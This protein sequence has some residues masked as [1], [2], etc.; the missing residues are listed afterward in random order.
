MPLSYNGIVP[1]DAP[2]RAVHITQILDLLTG[3]M[4]DQHVTLQDGLTV[5]NGVV[6][7]LTGNV[8][9]VVTGSLVGNASTATILQTARTINGVSF[10]GS[11]NITVTATATNTLTFG[12]HLTGTSY[13]GSTPITIA[14]DATSLDTG[15]TIVARDSSGNFSAGVITATLNGSAPAGTLTGT[16]LASNVVSSSL[17]SVGTL[18][19]LT[20]TATIIG[21]VSGNAGTA[22]TLQTPRTINGVSFDGSANITV[23][24]AAGTLT[25]ATLAAN[26]LASSLTS[27]GT[28]SALTVTATITGSVSGNAGTATTLQTPRTIN[29]VSFDGSANITITATPSGSAGG[30]LTGTYPNPSIANSVVTSAMI[31]DDTIVDADISGSA[32]ITPSKISGGVGLQE[33]YDNTLGSSQASITISSIP[34]TYK[35]L[36][37]I[38]KARTDGAFGLDTIKTQLNGVSSNSYDQS[39]LQAV[40][41]TVTAVNQASQSYFFSGYTAGANAPSSCFASTTSDYTDYAGSGFKNAISTSAFTDGVSVDCAVGTFIG[42]FASGSAVSSITIFPGSSPNFVTGTRIT[43][44][45]YN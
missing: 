18:A 41:G 12:T 25:G 6:G 16:V 33:I 20:V 27:V 32:A 14:T 26:V 22:T 29:G 31:V 7:N 35:H 15:S 17:T 13:N 24:A 36:R 10:D 11:S 28:L 40:N 38:I 23:A 43:L 19:S 2:V 21:S 45:G 37:L 5:N 4:N 3:I 34:N 42:L 8:A 44:Y 30:N 1:D 39:Y 9:G